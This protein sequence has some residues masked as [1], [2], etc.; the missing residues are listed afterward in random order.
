MVESDHQILGAKA[1][2]AP[3][4]GQHT[5]ALVAPNG[6]LPVSVPRNIEPLHLLQVKVS[7]HE[8]QAAASTGRCPLLCESLWSVGQRLV[9]FLQTSQKL[10]PALQHSSPQILS[11]PHSGPQHAAYQTISLPVASYKHE[12][13]YQVGD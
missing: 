12:E 6:P 4:P 2:P 7:A 11:G 13:N 5:E 9:F 1:T 10:K 3:I 8:L